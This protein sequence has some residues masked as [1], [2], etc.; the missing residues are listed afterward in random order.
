[1][2]TQTGRAVVA[3]VVAFLG[4]FLGFGEAQAQPL[5]DEH[6]TATILNRSTQVAPDGTFAIPNV[7]VD[8]GGLFRVRVVCDRGG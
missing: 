6:C 2:R 3:L 1:M 5:L 7:P 4:P 8:V